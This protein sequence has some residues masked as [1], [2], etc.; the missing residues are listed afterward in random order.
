[1][2]ERKKEILSYFENLSLLM[3]G[4]LFVLFPIFFLSS[5]TDAFVEPKELLLIILSSLSLLIFG[6]KTIIDGRLKLRTSPFDIPFTL[7][8][9]ITLASAIF[10]TDRYDALIAW[11]PLLFVGF[12]YFVIINTVKNQKQ[13]LFLLGTL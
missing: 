2:P 13:L 9:V 10:S 5:T 3:I 4:L 11:T 8:I 7:L 1:M 6:I 12:L